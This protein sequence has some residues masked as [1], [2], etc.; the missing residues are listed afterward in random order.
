MKLKAESPL[1]KSSRMQ[2][3]LDTLNLVTPTVP[4]VYIRVIDV[5]HTW[6]SI[7][8]PSLCNQVNKSCNE[9][10][11]SSSLSSQKLSSHFDVVPIFL[12][13]I[14]LIVFSN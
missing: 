7:Y 3:S 13:G 4:S 11:G 1:A 6:L 2:R 8:L 5:L 10:N 12:T 14:V 9:L